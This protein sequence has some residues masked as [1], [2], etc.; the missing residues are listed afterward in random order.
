[1]AFLVK[2]GQ[3]VVFI[4]DS[5]TDCGRRGPHAPLGE[6][7]V[8]VANDLI[9]AKYPA[10][11]VTVTNLGIGGNTVKDLYNRWSDELLTRPADWVSIAIGINDLSRHANK[12]EPRWSLDDFTDCYTR[13]LEW[14]QKES[15]ARLVI[16]DPFYTSLDTHEGSYRAMMLSHM[17]AYLEVTARLAKRFKAVHV[18]THEMFLEQLKYTTADRL[19]PDAVHPT[20]TGHLYMAH[21][22]LKA[23][24]W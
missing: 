19:S 23:M 9:H 5:V 13:L 14:T 12:A 22:W 20:A 21:A 6:G 17:P 24:G 1:M 11:N 16:M 10:H 7:Y 2:P 18:K 8:R 15:K 3:R 4:G